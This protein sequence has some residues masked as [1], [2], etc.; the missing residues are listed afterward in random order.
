MQEIT[1]EEVQKKPRGCLFIG[2]IVLLTA[3]LTMAITFFVVTRYI[4][5]TRFEPVTLSE[6]EQDVLE[7]KLERFEYA[8]SSTG[9]TAGDG[10]SQVGE[11]GNSDLAPEK[12][13]EAG[14][15][16]QITL[17]E[18]ELNGLLSA[19]TDLAERLV[20]DLSEN[21]ASGKLLIP[22]DPDFP[23]MGGKTLKI[24]AGMELAYRGD[25]PV[26][27]LRGV[28]VMGVPLP[29]AW[30]GNMKNVDLVRE[31]GADPGFWKSFAEGVENVRVSEGKLVVQLRE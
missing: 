22:L 4:F 21:L 24:T 15:N 3:V 28:S 6:S 10:R 23:I 29:A 27:V 9:K 5:P 20:I 7:A 14:A 30:L 17:S 25:K 2:G 19:N 31:F 1:A 18:R 26:V 11:S 12:Y 16:R 8:A 13:T